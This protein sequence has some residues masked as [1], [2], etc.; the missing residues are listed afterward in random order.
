MQLNQQHLAAL[1]MAAFQ[2]NGR[3]GMMPISWADVALDQWDGFDPPLP[4]QRFDRH[5]LRAFCRDKETPVFHAFVA[6]MA[7]G[8]QSARTG[9]FRKSV[10]EKRGQIEQALNGL[11]AGQGRVEAYNAWSGLVKGLGPSFFTKVIAFMS[12]S[13]DVAIMDQWA[14]KALHLLYGKEIVHLTPPSGDQKR[15]SPSGKN[16]GTRYSAYCAHL[17][18][19]GSALGL[20]GAS[21]VEERIFCRPDGPWREYVDR[22]WQPM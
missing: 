1:Q 18:H 5:E 14:V 10:E 12:P 2:P 7:W 9:E 15:C 13:D 20:K 16:D 4:R 11:R 6:I 8:R 17:E 21:A 19:L 22:N 3:G